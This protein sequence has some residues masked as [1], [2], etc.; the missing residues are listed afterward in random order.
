MAA[1][2]PT[3]ASTEILTIVR[4]LLADLA[5]RPVREILPETSLAAGLGLDSLAMIHL[6]VSIEE[7]FHVVVPSDASA[8]ERGIVTVSDLA[9]FVETL[10][11]IA[12]AS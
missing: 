5:E 12:R 2:Q 8:A 10:V 6:T 11:P 1:M 4:S 9:R 7:R 3:V